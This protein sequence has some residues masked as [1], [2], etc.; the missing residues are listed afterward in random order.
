[1]VKN[2]LIGSVEVIGA[3]TVLEGR[4]LFV[5][6]ADQLATIVFDFDVPS[7]DPMDPF[8]ENHTIGLIREIKKSFQGPMI[9]ASSSSSS[10]QMQME[11]GCAHETEKRHIARSVLHILNLR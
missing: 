7:G 6:Y 5:K 2:Q 10:R 4:E 1:M 11:H 9:V 8:A 3:T